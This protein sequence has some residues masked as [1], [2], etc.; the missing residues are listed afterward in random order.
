MGT[1]NPNY[2]WSLGV[3]D[4][5]MESYATAT[6]KAA[7][8]RGL[9]RDLVVEGRSING[10]MPKAFENWSFQATAKLQETTLKLR[11]GFGW[12]SDG[13]KLRDSQISSRSL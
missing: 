13:L 2:R 10:R 8:G 4:E 5:V 9:L 11:M 1:A 7:S 6:W 12:A 3:A